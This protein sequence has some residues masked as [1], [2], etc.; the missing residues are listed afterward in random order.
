MLSGMPRPRMNTRLLQ[1]LFDAYQTKID[2]RWGAVIRA[3]DRC[4]DL[5]HLLYKQ[6]E[7]L[8]LP[9][10]WVAPDLEDCDLSAWVC[11]NFG[12]SVR[13]PDAPGAPVLTSC[14]VGIPSEPTRASSGYHGRSL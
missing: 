14:T 4:W 6:K 12:K 9:R 3:A 1:S 7:P 5:Y 10:W 11:A 8:P 2:M 13:S